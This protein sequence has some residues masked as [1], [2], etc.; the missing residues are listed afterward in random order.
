MEGG[1]SLQNFTHIFD[2]YLI[3]L[4]ILYMTTQM[5]KS[6][7]QIISSIDRPVKFSESS[8]ISLDRA[9]EKT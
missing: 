1:D 6:P 4:I 7:Y 8:I 3:G 9:A 2:L 5:I